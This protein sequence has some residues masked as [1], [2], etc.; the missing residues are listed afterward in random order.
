[1]N[2]ILLKNLSVLLCT[3][4]L[5]LPLNAQT[6]EQQEQQIDTLGLVD[7]L[8]KDLDSNTPGGV[9]MIQKDGIVRYHKAFG[10]ADLE[11]GVEN[12]VQTVF[13]AGSVSKQFT[14]AALLLLITEGKVSLD[15]DVRKYIP[16]LPNYDEIITVRHL[17]NHTSGLRDWGSVASIGGWPRTTRVYTQDLAR[18]YIFR[19]AG[20]N[21]IPGEEY[22]YSNSNYTLLVTI[23][24]RVSGQALAD[25]TR[26]RFF[27]PLGMDK[28]QWRDDFRKLVPGR[29]I[30]YSSSN[31][32]IILNMPFEN[33]YGHAALLT[34][35]EDLITWN[36][37]WTAGRLAGDAIYDLRIQQGKLTNG[38]QISYAAAVRVVEKNG[39]T[40]VSHSGATAGYRAW[41]ADYPE[42]NLSV[43]YLGN[44]A[45]LSPVEIGNR[46]AEIYLG[47]SETSA[48][49]YVTRDIAPEELR[50]KD[51]LYKNITDHTTM[52][53]VFSEGKLFSGKNEFQAISPDTLVRNGTRYVFE[54]DEVSMITSTGWVI[55]ARVEPW[56]PQLQA[57][58]EF[59]GHYLSEEAAG[60]LH[61]EVVEGTLQA[62]I[63]PANREEMEPSFP[64]AFY[65]GRGKLYEF[66]RDDN[67]IITGVNV[68]V[69]RA[70][71]VY[72]EKI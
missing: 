48:P 28:T 41:L 2:S 50:K 36:E 32:K 9:L 20:L 45:N 40:E 17:L 68:S 38:T 5:A 12:D 31:G 4:L 44:Y 56:T 34:T 11:H 26:E 6:V 53:L 71:N 43:A 42:E 3:A 52:E 13:E 16:E 47:K 61:L 19:Q 21:N 27:E 72:F 60:A 62:E 54:G 18:D 37:S 58:E 67:G 55:Y 35:T 25:F 51:G 7:E 59:A 64:D 30:G 33:T 49:P 46:V 23:V 1:M 63:T 39:T 14:A 8:F 10:M 57:L 29:A 15:E 70:R 24:E 22:I 65:V 69:S 66:V